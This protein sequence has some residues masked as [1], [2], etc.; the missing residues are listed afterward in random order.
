MDCFE[1][2]KCK[3]M[4]CYDGVYLSEDDIKKINECIDK[5][6]NEFENKDYIEVSDWKDYKGM[7]KTKAIQL[8][9]Y[10]EDY[11]KHF[12]QTRC[13]FQNEET[14]KCLLQ[15]V[16]IKNNEDGWKY[17]PL[18]CCGFPLRKINGKV[19]LIKNK[20]D[21]PSIYDDYDGYV[22]C[23]PC[24]NKIDLNELNNEYLIMNNN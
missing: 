20:E 10:R 16:A 19:E 7:K 22:S 12:E 5:Y 17:K 2:F 23:L 21:D 4:C 18:T 24:F 15:E 13:I 6:P 11:P 1:K 9:R 8:T 14:G 3:G